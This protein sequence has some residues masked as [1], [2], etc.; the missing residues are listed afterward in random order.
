MFA[1]CVEPSVRATIVKR[2]WIGHG[3]ELISHPKANSSDSHQTH[4]C[5]AATRRVA[6]KLRGR[7][8]GTQVPAGTTI[9]IGI[10]GVHMSPDVWQEPTKFDPS[11]FLLP[12]ETDDPYAFLPFIQGPR[13]CLGQHLALLEARIVLALLAKVSP[14]G[15]RCMRLLEHPQRLRDRAC[16]KTLR[17]APRPPPRG[18]E[19]GQAAAHTP[20]AVHLEVRAAWWVPE[21]LIATR[22]CGVGGSAAV[23]V[24]SC[25]GGRQHQASD[26]DPYRA[27]SRAGDARRMREPPSGAAR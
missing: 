27:G 24:H 16:S 3:R 26:H 14:P 20:T 11:R 12:E 9:I 10:Q 2:D 5:T 17:A 25:A 19:R 13:N 8:G 15:I 6:T 4:H 22:W 23:H 21:R 1:A 18:T 7:W